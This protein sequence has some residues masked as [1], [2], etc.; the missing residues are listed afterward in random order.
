MNLL[1]VF[2]AKILNKTDTTLNLH[3]VQKLTFSLDIV[4]VCVW[5]VIIEPIYLR[6]VTNVGKV[7]CYAKMATLH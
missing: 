1:S 6:N 7:D 2:G 4:L 3:Q 5:K